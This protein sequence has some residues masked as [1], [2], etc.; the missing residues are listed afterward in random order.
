MVDE[1]TQISKINDPCAIY[2]R[3]F[4]APHRES[5]ASQ[6]IYE[7]RQISEIDDAG[8][9]NIAALPDAA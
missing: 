1:S 6:V 3:G 9:V 5:G 7:G 4:L 2:L 8:A